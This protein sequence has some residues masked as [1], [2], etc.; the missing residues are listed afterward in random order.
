[1]CKAA[2]LSQNN[3]AG[4]GWFM[5]RYLNKENI[6]INSQVAFSMERYS[7]SVDDLDIVCYFFDFQETME[8]PMKTQKSTNWSPGI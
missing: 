3:N 4:H 1:M 7:V 8:S 5:C 6:H 2:W